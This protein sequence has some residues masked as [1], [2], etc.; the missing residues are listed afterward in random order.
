MDPN[1][2]GYYFKRNQLIAEAIVITAAVNPS[3]RQEK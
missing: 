1:E 2:K 3:I